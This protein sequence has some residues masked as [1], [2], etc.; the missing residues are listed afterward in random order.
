MQSSHLQNYHTACGHP[1]TAVLRMFFTVFAVLKICTWVLTVH[2]KPFISGYPWLQNKLAKWKKRKQTKKSVFSFMLIAGKMTRLWILLNCNL[3]FYFIFF[4]KGADCRVP[5]QSPGAALERSG[6]TLQ[7]SL[8][9]WSF[10]ATQI[11]HSSGLPI[12]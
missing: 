7:C 11:S 1:V 12:C 3:L 6:S 10:G 5:E 9:P 4:N 8:W 2:L